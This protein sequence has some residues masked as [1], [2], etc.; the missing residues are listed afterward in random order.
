MVAFLEWPEA[1]SFHDLLYLARELVLRFELSCTFLQ[2]VAG[3]LLLCNRNP[4]AYAPLGLVEGTHAAMYNTSEEF[5]EK[6]VYYTRAEHDHERRAIVAAAYKQGARFAKWRA[7][8]KIS[9]MSGATPSQLSIDQNAY[10]LARYAAICQANGLVPI[11]EPEVLMDGDH[12]IEQVAE[13]L[14]RSQETD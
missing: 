4:T 5:E 9:D 2:L 12:S 14:V 6:L 10:T 13:A 11:V 7:V 1:L 8:L 3:I